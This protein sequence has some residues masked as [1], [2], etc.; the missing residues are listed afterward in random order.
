MERKH[1]FKILMKPEVPCWHV[2]CH[3]TLPLIQYFNRRC[4]NCRITRTIFSSLSQVTPHFLLYNLYNHDHQHNPWQNSLTL[5]VHSA[6]ELSVA[7]VE[8]D[9]HCVFLTSKHGE[10][11]SFLIKHV[12]LTLKG[13]K[14]TFLFTG[15]FFLIFLGTPLHIL[16]HCCHLLMNS[17]QEKQLLKCN[18]TGNQSISVGIIRMNIFKPSSRH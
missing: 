12:E 3:G 16:A 1:D 5:V 14:P 18:T 17:V 13:L 9:L 2:R 4:W 15:Y 6:L 10:W 8:R 11:I 7:S